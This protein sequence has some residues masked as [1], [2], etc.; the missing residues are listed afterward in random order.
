MTATLPAAF[1][2]RLTRILPADRLD[3]VLASFAAVKDVAFRINTLKAQPDAVLAGLR[4][5]GLNPRPVAWSPL[6]WVV[7]AAAK[8]ALTETPAFYQGEIYIQNLASQLAPWQWWK[9]TRSAAAS[10]A[11][12]STAGA[13]WAAGATASRCWKPSRALNWTPTKCWPAACANCP[14]AHGWS[15]GTAGRRRNSAPARRGTAC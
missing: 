8:R 6:A 7:D 5:A 9:K 3:G 10:S 15:R 14:K 11:M 4:A 1:A 2:D 13:F 12:C